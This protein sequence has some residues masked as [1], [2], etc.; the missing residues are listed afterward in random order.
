MTGRYG[1]DFGGNAKLIESAERLARK[2]AAMAGARLHAFSVTELDDRSDGWMY[3]IV[4]GLIDNEFP[5]KTAVR[6]LTVGNRLT[7]AF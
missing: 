3:L 7:L 6:V 2:V 1:Y 4:D 5:F